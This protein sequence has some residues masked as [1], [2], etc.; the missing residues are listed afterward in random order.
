MKHANTKLIL[1]ALALIVASVGIL[2]GSLYALEQAP[3]EEKPYQA[4]DPIEQTPV[5]EQS[6]PVGNWAR[7]TLTVPDDMM[8]AIYDALEDYSDWPTDYDS[9]LAVI[10]NCTSSTY[11]REEYGW[12]CSE[13]LLETYGTDDEYELM[14]N[15]RQFIKVF[16]NHGEYD[17]TE[18]LLLGS[19][20]PA[21][22]VFDYMGM[23]TFEVPAGETVFFDLRAMGFD[24]SELRNTVI[25]S[26]SYGDNRWANLEETIIDYITTAYIPR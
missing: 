10:R 12:L 1:T 25:V 5:E 18:T 11:M 14:V 2:S 3:V 7:Q 17:Y 19:R 22:G 16:E 20:N 23:V 21:E 15:Q 9:E 8:D 6:Y 24:T 13:Y 26:A 4:D